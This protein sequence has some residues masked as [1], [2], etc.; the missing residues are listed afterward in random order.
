ME[1]SQGAGVQVHL[2][3]PWAHTLSFLFGSSGPL[4]LDSDSGSSE[5]EEEEEE[6]EEAL[7]TRPPP[8]ARTGPQAGP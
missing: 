5:E 2:V 4:A 8:K 3:S 6:E 7:P 1:I